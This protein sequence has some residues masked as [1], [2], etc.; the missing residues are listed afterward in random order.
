MYV[1]SDAPIPQNGTMPPPARCVNASNAL[2]A[3]AGAVSQSGRLVA[4]N[5]V[6]TLSS[7]AQV[8]PGVAGAAATIL[9]QSELAR[10]SV[11]AGA[12]PAPG[13]ST[14]AVRTTGRPVPVVVPLN[15]IPGV[16]GMAGACISRV[17]PP[18]TV[19]EPAVLMPK[20]L[21]PLPR[22]G[23]PALPP[24][25]AVTRPAAVVPAFP[26]VQGS[27]VPAPAPGYPDRGVGSWP[28][29]GCGTIQAGS[30]VFTQRSFFDNWMVALNQQAAN[31][32]A[33]PAGMSGYAPAWGDSLVRARDAGGVSSWLSAN[34]WVPFGVVAVGVLAVLGSRGGRR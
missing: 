34:L 3:L 5:T 19:L 20:P 11:L 31:N 10:Q 25:A 7:L 32:C 29:M 12:V 33:G 24:P 17:P 6:P 1:S 30:S 23:P 8:S 21:P 16:E 4:Y 9:P 18:A 26:S 28:A 22:P 27:W 15:Y 14:L 13:A 2:I